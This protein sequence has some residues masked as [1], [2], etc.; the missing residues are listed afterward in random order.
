MDGLF[1]KVTSV[2]SDNPANFIGIL[3]AE[4]FD[5]P[6]D[7]DI[8]HRRQDGEAVS[9]PPPITQSDVDA[10]CTAAVHTA[11]LDWQVG[12]EQARTVAITSLNTVLKGMN[13]A[14]ERNTLAVAEG[15]V[16]T[17]LAM[18]AGL[19]PDF[20]REHGPAEIRALLGRLLP[21]IRSQER[22]SVRV[23]PDLIAAIQRDLT[24]LD[25]DLSTK[26]DVIAAPLERGDVKVAWENGS[27]TRDTRQIAQAIQDA[28]S[29][30]GL[31]QT[32][33]APAK[34]SMA[35]AD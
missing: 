18:V 3:Y 8:H 22:I 24:E 28:L 19:L 23:H 10:A 16:A 14:A 4:D 21:T 30:L 11:R 13:A 9:A 27:M 34:R 29:Q 32:T 7:L 6:V 26:V 17:I 20:A 33:E 15:T 25:G 2:A 35:Y 31:R 12:L 1:S 5:D